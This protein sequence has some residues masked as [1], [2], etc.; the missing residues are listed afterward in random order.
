MRKFYHLNIEN[1]LI[2][3]M[4][5]LFCEEVC[6]TFGFS[7]LEKDKYDIFFLV[8]PASHDIDTYADPEPF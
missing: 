4:C 6:L 7:H 1:V 3:L 8:W 5:E 2:T